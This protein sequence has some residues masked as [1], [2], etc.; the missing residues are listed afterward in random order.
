MFEQLLGARSPSWQ[1]LLLDEK[2]NVKSELAGVTGGSI[3]LAATTRLG[4]SGSLQLTDTGQ[5]V[6]WLK[7]RVRISYNPGVEEV[8][9]WAVATMLFSSPQL[10]VDGE[11]RTF[12]VELLSTLAVV[13]EDTFEDPYAI[14]AGSNIIEKVA[15]IL[16]TSTT[17]Q[18]MITPSELQLRSAMFFPAG[19]SKLTI[20]NELLQAANYWSLHTDGLGRLIVAPY[21]SPYQRATSFRFESGELSIHT[22]NW[23]REQDIASVPNRFIVR[24]AG[25]EEKEAIV[26]VARDENPDSPYSFAS[27]GRWVTVTEEVQELADQKAA[28][29]LAE[30]RLADRMSPVAKLAV[31]FAVLPLRPNE[32]VE[33]VDSGVDTR[34]TLQRLAFDLSWDTVCSADLR[35]VLG[36]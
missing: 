7:D 36:G 17:V 33:F 9:P 30:R 10:R 12:E 35:E 16:S 3:E 23:G 24:T 21:S 20:I 2:Q 15:E 34:A 14:E 22:P 25:D 18:A 28:D 27:R 29:A 5:Q 1:I 31:S 6:D 4:A 11:N 32:V 8:T 26:G 13:D 19:E